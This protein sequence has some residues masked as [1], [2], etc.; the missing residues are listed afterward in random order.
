[1]HETCSH[2]GVTA[3]TELAVTDMPGVMA[4]TDLAVTKGPGVTAVTDLAVTAGRHGRD[5]GV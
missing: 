1:M 3:V 2:A 5:G 4:V